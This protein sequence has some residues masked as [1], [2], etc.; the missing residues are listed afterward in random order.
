MIIRICL[1]LFWLALFVGCSDARKHDTTSQTLPL[2]QER[3]SLSGQVFIVTQGAENVK[4][5]LIE[6][7]LIDKE[8]ATHFA[9]QKKTQLESNLVSLIGLFTNANSELALVM[10]GYDRFL[11]TNR[12]KVPEITQQKAELERLTRE[13]AEGMKATVEFLEFSD[14][15]DKEVA[16]MRA[17]G[18]GIQTLQRASELWR[19]HERLG[20]S[21]PPYPSWRE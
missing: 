16:Q 14:R 8:W 5:G 4:L 21:S 20:A 9:E 10:E 12:L 2:A 13:Y 3:Y 19:E 6:V 1:L 11:A 17:R 18:L 7:Q 15:V